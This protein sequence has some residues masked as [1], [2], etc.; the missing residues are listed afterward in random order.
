MSLSYSKAWVGR[1]AMAL[2]VIAGAA[3]LSSATK[4]T[5][6][7]P[8]EKAYYADANKISFVR[9][10]LAIKIVSAKIADDGTLSVDYKLT[11]PKGLGLD[12]LGVTTPGAISVSFLVTYI[13]KGQT[14][15]V[16]YITRN[17]TSTDGKNTVVQ[18]T[19][20][21]T[22]VQTS[23][24]DGEYLY[25]FAAKLPKTF[26]PTATHR[27][28]IY[29]SRNL[30][31]FD[32]GTN[33][34]S[35]IF[36][37]VPA[38]GK[39]A[40][41]EVIKTASCD[42]CHDQLAF[43]GG[44]RRGME[45]CIMCHQPQTTE[46]N[47][48][49]TVDMKVMV[50]KI[51]MGSQLP[52]VV[53]K[54]KYAIGSSDWSTVELPSDPRRCAECHESTTGAAQANAWYTNPTRAACGSCHDNVNFATGANHVNLPQ[55]DDNQCATCHIP[56][57]EL[58]LDASIQGAHVI[59][60][61]SATA[62]GIVINLMKVD[63]GAA[64]K[65][66]TITFTLKDKAGK[67][68]DPATLVTSPNKISF[69]LTGPTTDYG[70]TTFAGVTSPGYVSEAAAALSK[71]G[72]DGTCTYTFTH[73]IPADAKGSFAIGVEA[74]RALMVLPGTVKQVSTQ[75]GVDNKVIYFS[76][77]GSP[78]V[79]RRQV[80]DT[81]KCNQCHVRLSLHGENR[82]QTEYCVFCHNPKNTSGTVSGI[83]FAV[84]VHSIHFG[85]NLAAAGAT[86]KIGTA[87]FSEVRYP[88]FS[89]TGRPGDTTNCQMCHLPGTEA[90]FPIGL[91]TVKTPGALMDQAPAT[92][93]ACGACHV[94][95]SNMAHM[96]AQTDPKFGESC[97]VCH[98]VNGDYSVLKEHAK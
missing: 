52:S 29:G 89:N 50:H 5:V 32:L 72:Q 17:R 91:N 36:D 18:A 65:L 4:K 13:P 66:P 35:E 31:E 39:P 21:N 64:G 85:E 90:V 78:M 9:P 67:P 25:T 73:A 74:R 81:A 22:G 55:V 57:G 92:T 49:Q 87:D 42:K 8:H 19:G 2:A 96:A 23:L 44:S 38:G 12:R 62:P 51:H 93:A 15:Y 94:T 6:F 10:G 98:G 58:D 1:C 7:T 30:T 34:D 11:D 40:P 27:V 69:V 41:R 82:N 59:P 37:W 46:A 43:H 60:N 83:N 53:A 14:Q 70:N 20:E 54:G 3:V 75:Y 76:V 48:N 84:M 63:N 77:D 26:D 24:G 68:I 71:C 61:E 95:K 45:I 97:D 80:V 86:Y 16:S 28:G 33:Y 88:A 79:K 47:G 56:K